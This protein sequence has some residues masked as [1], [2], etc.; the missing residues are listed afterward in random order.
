MDSAQTIGRPIPT[1]SRPG[2]GSV[3]LTK[4]AGQTTV[5]RCHSTSPL[6][7]LTPRDSSKTARI[8]AATFGGGLLDGDAINLSLTA[9]PGTKCLLTTQ[10]S[11][12]IYRSD[13]VGSSQRITI[14]ADDD[15]LIVSLPDPIVCFAASR[16]QQ[17]QQFNLSPTASL[18]MLD[19]F[20]SGRAARAER[21][22]MHHFAAHTEIN[23]AG[24]C[25]F[26]DSLELDPIDGKIA[27]PMRMG[28]IDCFATVAL[29][30]PAFSDRANNLVQTLQK[31]PIAPDETILFGISQLPGA[32]VIR[33]AAKS[34]ERAVGWLS[35]KLA[36]ITPLL[37]LDPWLRK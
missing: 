2:T 37:G 36:F 20:T 21:W 5:T 17:R 13:S 15:A 33:L 19:S 3:Q 32:T 28:P 22:Q 4:I 9:D 35:E 23:V 10:A 24:K 1:E 12:K 26:R 34:A 11:T 27:A 18:L 29:V 25:I 16:F 7:I 30:G 6:R 31:Q 8:V 14:T